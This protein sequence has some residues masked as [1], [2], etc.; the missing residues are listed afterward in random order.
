M[1]FPLSL[2]QCSMCLIV[3]YLS[4]QL[5]LCFGSPLLPLTDAVYIANGIWY[6]RAS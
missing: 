4:A 1:T 6:G 5:R 3:T 2:A